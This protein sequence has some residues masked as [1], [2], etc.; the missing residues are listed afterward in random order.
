MMIVSPT[1]I[2]FPL[3]ANASSSVSTIGSGTIPDSSA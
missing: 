1:T 3:N 2:E